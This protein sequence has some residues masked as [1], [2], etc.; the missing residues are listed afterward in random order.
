MG[1]PCP[2][3]NQR[4]AWSD[5]ATMAKW[6]RDV[7]LPFVRLHLAMRPVLLIMDNCG[8]HASDEKLKELF[9]DDKGLVDVGLLPPNTT[10]VWQPMDAGIIAYVK[11]TYKFVAGLRHRHRRHLFA[12]AGDGD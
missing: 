5:T 7:F 6:W 9:K 10:P 11:S 2:Y 8:S 4:R 1:L 3:F 12:A